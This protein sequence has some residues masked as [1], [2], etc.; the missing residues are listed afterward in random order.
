[1]RCGKA[2]ILHPTALKQKRS[3]HSSN[4]DLRGCVKG[5]TSIGEVLPCKEFFINICVKTTVMIED[6]LLRQYDSFQFKKKDTI[7]A[8]YDN[9]VPLQKRP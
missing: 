6:F 9:I 4:V 7:S 3:L 5:E 8:D 2:I 1:M